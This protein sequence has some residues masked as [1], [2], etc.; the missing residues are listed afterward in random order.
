MW[1]YWELLPSVVRSTTFPFPVGGT[2]L[3]QPPILREFYGMPR[4]RV[5]DETWG[6]SG[7]NKDR[8]TALII[9][10]TSADSRV[11]TTA[12]T[13]NAAISTTLA[14]AALG[15]TAV[16]FVGA[17]CE[18]RKLS[19]MAR[20]GA[21]LCQ[22]SQGYAAARERSSEAASAFGWINRNTGLNPDTIEAK[23]TVAFEIWEQLGR[24]IP[25]VVM[26]PVGDGPTLVA[27]YK[28]FDELR[29]C[30]MT[31]RS[32]RLIGVQAQGCAPIVQSWT[33]QTGDAVKLDSAA[34][35]FADGIAVA[36]P[37]AST[38]VVKAIEATGGEA[39]AVSDEDISD[40]ITRYI[41]YA[42]LVPEPAGAAALAGL[43][44]A[45]ER[46]L[47]GSQELA[48]VLVTGRDLHVREDTPV[49]LNRVLTDPEL[50]DLAAALH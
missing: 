34:H 42:G 8:A 44:Y 5:K 32:P 45:R 4:L 6:F 1:R 37:V 49:L 46:Q 12:S 31:H 47:V 36:D 33:A 3:I 11:I 14:A 50:D 23:K 22:M 10:S 2:P 48:V 9:A 20:A 7:S 17:D 16:I 18:A 28:G 19:L 26:A 21:V 35:S 41:M 15:M 27:L 40:A 25:D 13:G 39:L 43:H 30:G 29:E 24:R 38:A